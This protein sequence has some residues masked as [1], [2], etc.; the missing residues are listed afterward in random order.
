MLLDQFR[1]GLLEHRM[2]ARGRRLV[3]S[4]LQCR[5]KRLF[6]VHFC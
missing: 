4:M 3:L 5:L 6:L 1:D 2:L